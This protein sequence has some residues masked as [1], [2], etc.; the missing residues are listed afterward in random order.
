MI[1]GM[2]AG[3]HHAIIAQ[4]LIAVAV[5]ILIGDEIVIDALMIEPVIEMRIGIILVKAGAMAAEPGMIFRREIEIGPEPR[6]ITHARAIGMAVIKRAAEFGMVIHI[7]VGVAE[8]QEARHLPLGAARGDVL[9]MIGIGEI[10]GGRSQYQDLR[11]AHPGI[12][13]ARRAHEKGD[14][15]LAR[16]L[17][18]TLA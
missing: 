4:K 13:L 5:E 11:S 7:E 16:R 17:P 1:F 8:L 14:I 10:G 6:G 3:H 12:A 18:I 9:A 15:L 2:G